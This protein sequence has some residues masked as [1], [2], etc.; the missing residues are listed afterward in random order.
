MNERFFAEADIEPWKYA[1][2]N[3]DKLILL[4]LCNV[5]GNNI[6]TFRILFFIFQFMLLMNII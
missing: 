4:Q 2:T 6:P 5:G 1:F 3:M